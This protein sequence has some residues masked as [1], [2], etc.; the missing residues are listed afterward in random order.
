MSRP[1]SS[2]H[3]R[4]ASSGSSQ[5]ENGTGRF[6]CLRR[7]KRSSSAA[8]TVSPSMTRAAAGSW[9]N[10]LMPRTFTGLPPFTHGAQRALPNSCG[11]AVPCLRRPQT[12]PRTT[13]AVLLGQGRARALTCMNPCSSG[14]PGA[15]RISVI[16]TGYL[17]ATHAVALA[18]CGHEVVGIDTDEH[19]VRQLGAAVAPFHEPGFPALL[20]E[21]V[22]GGSLTFDTDP[23]R[24]A[25]AEV[26]FLCVGTPQQAGS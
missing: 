10:A 18:S 14:N 1:A 8:A 26:H 9:N 11:E 4:A 21:G 22:R 2:R 16:G 6:P 20:E 24:A 25:G 12:G 17:G 19:R 15:V 7:L 5:A 23:R 3:Q 13:S